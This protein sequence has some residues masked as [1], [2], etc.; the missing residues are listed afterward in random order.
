MSHAGLSCFIAWHQCHCGACP[1]NAS[2]LGFPRYLQYQ[3]VHRRRCWRALSVP[4]SSIRTPCAVTAPRPRARN[5]TSQT[6]QPTNRNPS[7]LLPAL[8]S[9]RE[10]NQIALRKR[11]HDR[12]GRLI[13]GSEG[14]LSTQ[15]RQFPVSPTRMSCYRFLTHT[16][17]SA[18]R[19][20]ERAGTLKDVFYIGNVRHRIGNTNFGTGRCCATDHRRRGV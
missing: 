7:R 5:V 6:P 1:V 20:A 18:N 13:G 12:L 11:R 17:C 16:G 15:S 9:T 8:S 4:H 19:V 2:G 10:C 14:P 3:P